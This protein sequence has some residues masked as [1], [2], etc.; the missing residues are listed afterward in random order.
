MNKRHIPIFLAADDRYL[1][2]L[3]VAV[4]SISDHSSDE[5]IYDVRILSSEIPRARLH[6]LLDMNL[7]NVKIS[8]VNIDKRISGIREELSLRLRDYY[9]ESIYY[10]LFI[11]SMFPELNRAL[12]IDCDVVLVDD[13]AKM[14]FTDIGD[15][16]LG[17]V[18]DESIPGV[19][20]FC[21]YVDRWVGVPAGEYFNSGVLVMNLAKMRDE[22]IEEKFLHLLGKYN[23]D[24]VAPDQDYL[25]CLCKGRVRYLDLAWNK[26][27]KEENPIPVSEL[28]LIHYNMVN[29]PWHY[30]GILYEQEFWRVA[31]TT[32]FAEEIRR[33]FEGYTDEQRKKDENGA[34]R[35]VMSAARIAD[36]EGGFASVV[37]RELAESFAQ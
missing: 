34:M 2:Y 23:F 16:I 19:S 6:M 37:G 3:A 18:A 12:Y 10:R 31:D 9:S 13:I 35:L 29:K 20:A 32:P 11:P 14:Y 22:K 4:K 33:D 17:A 36:E 27:P 28:H 30:S 7:K 1:P 24:T 21:D 5:Y 15:N 8:T 25:N 26:Q